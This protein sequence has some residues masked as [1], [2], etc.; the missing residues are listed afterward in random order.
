M[1][2][3]FNRKCKL[4]VLHIGM[5]KCGTSSIQE[6]L[7]RNYNL[8]GFDE[9][10]KYIGYLNKHHL[11]PIIAD[12]IDP[13]KLPSYVTEILEN[14]PLDMPV[15][16]YLIREI[17]NSQSKVTIVSSEL[18]VHWLGDQEAE[19]FIMKLKHSLPDFMNI[20]VVCYFRQPASSRFLSNLQEQ[21][22]HNS[23]IALYVPESPFSENIIAYKRWEQLCKK[24]NISWHPRLFSR[25]LF[26]NGDVIADFF[27]LIETMSDI[28]IEPSMTILENESMDP[29]VLSSIRHVI[30]P[31][32]SYF[33][34]SKKWK[35]L[36]NLS[37][38]ATQYLSEKGYNP[39]KC[40]F[41]PPLEQHINYI[42]REEEQLSFE[43]YQ[44][45]EFSQSEDIYLNELTLETS[46]PPGVVRKNRYLAGNLESFLVGIDKEIVKELTL[47]LKIANVEMASYW[48]AGSSL[49]FSMPKNS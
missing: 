7:N 5:G 14:H 17:I 4:L 29:V 35:I 19:A 43:N 28:K 18:I 32:F 47:Y 3:F 15:T 36:K 16:E 2:K 25:S 26:I 8:H 45:K 27:S 46:L 13:L 40:T 10:I 23:E 6:F 12:Y 48:N 44:P 39:P 31:Y 30:A 11:H 1:F 38:I 34:F 49:T 9:N 20:A 41:Y 37:T 24:H 33:K 42:S 22:K 21:A